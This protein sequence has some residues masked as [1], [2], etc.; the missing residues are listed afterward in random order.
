MTHHRK[1]HDFGRKIAKR[2]PR[3]EQVVARRSAVALMLSA[4]ALATT[5]FCIASVGASIVLFLAAFIALGVALC[6]AMDA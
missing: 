1:P 4:I 3:P 2:A 6:A 5:A